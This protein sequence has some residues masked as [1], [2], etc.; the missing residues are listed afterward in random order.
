M[1]GPHFVYPSPVDG[2]LGGFLF[3]EALTKGNVFAFCRVFFFVAAVLPQTC[4]RPPLL[5]FQADF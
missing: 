2:H 3:L 5:D 1:R 4:E